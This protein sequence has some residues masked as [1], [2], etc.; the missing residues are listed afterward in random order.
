MLDFA[1]D[2][3]AAR[4]L[5]RRARERGKLRPGPKTAVPGVYLAGAWTDTGWPATMESAVRSGL[6]AAALPRSQ[7]GDGRMTVTAD[8]AIDAGQARLGRATEHLLSLQQPA[9]YWKGELETNVTIDSEDLFLRHF[10]GLLEPARRRANRDAG[11]ARSSGRTARGRRTSAAPA[12]S[13]PPSRPTSALRLAGDPADAAHMK[14][15]AAFV[16]EAGGVERQPRL[17]AHVALAA[18][19]LVVGGRADAAARA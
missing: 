6:A 18:R 8:R 7:R 4:D 5:P 16:R 10:L 13:R 9:G 17:H 2:A 1:V 3:R 12:T 11:S 19:P 14:R 15:A